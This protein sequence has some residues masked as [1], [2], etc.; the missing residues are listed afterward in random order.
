[1]SEIIS[2]ADLVSWVDCGIISNLKYAEH[3]SP[4][5]KKLNIE[6][7]MFYSHFTGI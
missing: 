1:M 3:L 4:L 2:N 6:E 5:S 7:N